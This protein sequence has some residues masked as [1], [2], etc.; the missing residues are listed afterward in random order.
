MLYSPGKWSVWGGGGGREGC[1]CVSVCVSEDPQ[2]VWS[3]V[4]SSVNM[5]AQVKGESVSV[6]GLNV[7]VNGLNVSVN[8]PV[9]PIL[10]LQKPQAD[11]LSRYQG[12][13]SY[14]NFNILMSEPDIRIYIYIFHIFKSCWTPEKL[15][16]HWTAVEY[17]GA[18]G[19][20]NIL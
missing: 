19:S 12:E 15:C 14:C 11:F 8:G 17:P 7:S 9:M 20:T 5:A 10:G 18:D 6:N 1:L 2:F 4:G 3:S 16:L 13:H